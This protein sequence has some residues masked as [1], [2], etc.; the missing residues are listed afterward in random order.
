MGSFPCHYLRK[1]LTLTVHLIH[2]LADEQLL[3]FETLAIDHFPA[4]QNRIT[5]IVYQ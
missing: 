3:V 4:Q 2:E 5:L 1:Y